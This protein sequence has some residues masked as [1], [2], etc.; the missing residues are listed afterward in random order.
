MKDSFG[1][2]W[3]PAEGLATKIRNR[4]ESN[5]GNPPVQS[6]KFNFHRKMRIHSRLPDGRVVVR[7]PG[8]QRVQVFGPEAGRTDQ[9][10]YEVG[11]LY[12]GS[13]LYTD[14][15]G[16]TF[17]ETLD[18]SRD[19]HTGGGFVTH[20]VVMGPDGAQL[21]TLSK[22]SSEYEAPTLTAERSGTTTRVVP[23]SPE[24]LWTI[25]PSGHF[26]TGL[27]SE[28]RI[29]LARDDRVLRIERGADP[30]PVL[31]EE[32]AYERGR[33]VERMRRRDPDWSWNGPPI[34]AH[35]PFF[36]ELLAGRDG[37]IWVR[38][39]TEGYAVENADH[40]PEDPSSVP[41]VWEE[42]LRYDVFEP[43]G[44]YLG[45]VV[46][47]DGFAPR[48]SPVFE[49]D[50]VWGVTRDELGVQRVVRYRIVVGGG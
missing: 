47:P 23:F 28:Y 34:P 30:V 33:I 49:G 39:S 24:L 5:S 37:R 42:S 31:D 40:D 36:K 19:L 3:K 25:H 6:R 48:P 13:P 22:P 50:H 21:A 12:S 7:D 18:L 32:R 16:R 11:G 38:L 10:G 9:W 20:L 4:R 1:R 14:V 29:D 46:P 44:T 41:V 26:L 15:H 43:D 8:N 17:V 35:K 27:S 2:H 45:V